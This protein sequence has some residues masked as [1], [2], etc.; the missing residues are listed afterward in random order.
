MS[1]A[2]NSIFGNRIK[3]SSKVWNPSNKTSSIIL[4]EKYDVQEYKEE[5]PVEKIVKRKIPKWNH[6]RQKIEKTACP[7][8]Y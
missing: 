5:G 6:P 2:E 8:I 7:P 4:K 3:Q 1:Q